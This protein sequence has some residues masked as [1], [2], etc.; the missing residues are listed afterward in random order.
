MLADFERDLK[1]IEDNERRI[2][3]HLKSKN[4]SK[5]LLEKISNRLN[6]YDPKIK[7]LEN[8][9]FGNNKILRIRFDANKYNNNT[10]YTRKAIQRIGDDLSEYLDRKGIKGKLMT[11]INFPDLGWRS[12][13]FSDIGDEVR[14]YTP[15]DSDLVADDPTSFNN[16]VMYI[17]MAPNDVGGN[18]KY[19]D[20]LYNC[21]YYYL[22]DKLP[23]DT[24]AK[25]KKFLNLNRNDKVPISSI[26]KIEEKLKTFAIYIRG[27]YVYSSTVKSQKEI[28][29]LLQNE[30]YTVDKSISTN[31]SINYR[32]AYE[33]KQPILY[34]KLTFEIFDGV[35]KRKISKQ[36]LNDILY[37]YKSK[38]ILID[39]EEKKDSLSLEEE[40]KQLIQ[41]ID[42]IK[43]ATNG[44][45]NLRKTGNIKDT[46]L[47]LFDKFT[48]YLKTPEQILQD[49]AEW[50]HNTN[51]GAI[52]WAEPYSGTGYKYDI[53]SMYPSIMISSGKF[54]IGRGE[55]NNL[56][57]L[58]NITYFQFGIYRCKVI[59]DDNNINNKLFRFNPKHYY[60]HTSLEHAKILGLKIELIKDDKP[61]FLYYPREK[62]IGF[63][64]VFSKYVDF[65]FDLKQKKIP[66]AKDILNRLWGVLCELDR[67]QYF[68]SSDKEI[69][70]SPDDEIISLRP[71]KLDDDIDIMECVSKK[72]YYKTSFARLSPFL[73]SRGRFNISNIILPH[74]ENIHRIHTDGFISDSKLD[75]K[76]GENIGD[77]VF[78]GYCENCNI[79]NCS[80]NSGEFIL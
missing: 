51:T 50:I 57:T 63:N 66:K 36:E 33:E 22:F 19:N 11:S 52:I 79:L 37:N 7:L 8:I 21:L 68:C 3:K 24:P 65:V 12:G 56:N 47:D 64:E 18:D 74:K 60:T 76:L 15:Q 75:I 20:C 59:K 6:K 28:N 67:K 16:F 70:L 2:K 55:F 48:K 69:N 77:L 1:E 58:D 80:N 5:K 14:L 78:E 72:N 54:P 32:V 31:K 17:S 53:K 71:Y 38:Y 27:D 39:R 44:I 46:A 34:D 35:E 29:L 4:Y 61:N 25:L 10:F 9:K 13:Y 41:D 62:L 43:I 40:Y 73:I 45:I 26:P 49:E 23:W 30:H 42:T